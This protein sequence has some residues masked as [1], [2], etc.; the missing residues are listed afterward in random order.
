MVRLYIAWMTRVIRH[1]ATEYSC[2]VWGSE[3]PI[4]RIGFSIDKCIFA[5]LRLG[6]GSRS[7]G[8]LQAGTD[9][10]SPAAPAATKSECT[11]H[12]VAHRDKSS[13]AARAATAAVP[14]K[15]ESS[16]DDLDAP[17]VHIPPACSQRAEITLTL[18]L[19]VSGA[20]HGGDD[21]IRW[22]CT[23]GASVQCHP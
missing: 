21:S 19:C 11:T 7:T 6:S 22:P 15:A 5:Q 20:H 3:L 14:R 23:G 17:H 1:H 13:K 16:V 12:R 18:F 4:A 10:T 2:T 8:M 9:T